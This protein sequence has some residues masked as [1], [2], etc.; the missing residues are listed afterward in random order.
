[1]LELREYLI[2]QQDPSNGKIFY[3]IESS[4]DNI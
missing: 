1:M 4:L 2:E 3:D